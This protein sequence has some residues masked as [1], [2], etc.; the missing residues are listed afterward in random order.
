MENEGNG[1]E[2]DS[3]CS[4]PE[5]NNQM[6]FCNQLNP[7]KRP[8]FGIGVPSADDLELPGRNE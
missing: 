7:A 4:E 5:N 1:S 3:G 6:D 8:N 2:S